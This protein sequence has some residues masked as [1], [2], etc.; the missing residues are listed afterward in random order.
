MKRRKAD[1]TWTIMGYKQD[2]NPRAGDRNNSF[3]DDTV[4]EGAVYMPMSSSAHK[5]QRYRY[6]VLI[7]IVGHLTEFWYPNLCLLEEQCV[8]LTTAL[9]LQTPKLSSFRINIQLL[10]C[11]TPSMHTN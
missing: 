2:I 6:L 11:T 8:V 3:V 4:Y 5:C 10:L 1:I 9:Y 7:A